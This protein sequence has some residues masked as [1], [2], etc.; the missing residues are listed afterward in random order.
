M[1]KW[2]A[3]IALAVVAVV[4]S[5]PAASAGQDGNSTPWFT[6]HT[7]DFFTSCDGNC[8]FAIFGGREVKTDMTK[9]FLIEHPVAPWHDRVGNAGIIAGNF[10]RRFLTVLNIL[11]FETEVGV[12]QRF[13]NMH[14]TENWLALD[15]RWT[16]FPWNQYVRTTIGLAEG[17]SYAYEIDMEERLRADNNR[18]SHFLNFFTPEL[19]LALPQLPRDEL[20]FRFQHRSGAFGAINGVYGGSSFATVGYRHRF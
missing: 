6:W 12:G 15:V 9:A 18:G 13:G 7:H 14:A 8:A 2:I 11:D 19:T 10:S 5:I 16:W 4:G 1:T 3:A 20:I 17:V